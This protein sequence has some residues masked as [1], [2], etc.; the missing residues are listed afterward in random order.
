MTW[1]QY[2]VCKPFV[3]NKG[4][5]TRVANYFEESV[6]V[7]LGNLRRKSFRRNRSWS[8]CR[9]HMGSSAQSVYRTHG[10]MGNRVDLDREGIARSAPRAE[11]LL[12]RLAQAFQA[13]LGVF[14]F[15]VERSALGHALQDLD[16]GGGADVI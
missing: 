7:K 16:G 9:R 8:T 15:G 3:G 4:L 6:L 10:T 2:M 13:F 1:V 12:F 5:T 14:G 11:R